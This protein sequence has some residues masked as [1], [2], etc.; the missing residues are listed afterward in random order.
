MTVPDPSAPLGFVRGLWKSH[1]RKAVGPAVEI[2]SALFSV[3]ASARKVVA[4]AGQALRLTQRALGG[5]D[6]IV[7]RG[8][9][10]RCVS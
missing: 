6:R 2:R 5:S 10:S 3:R 1:T 8:V 7:E 9:V 4:M